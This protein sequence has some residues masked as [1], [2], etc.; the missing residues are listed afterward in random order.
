VVVT[1]DVDNAEDNGCCCRSP[2][3]RT[4]PLLF[5]I[6]SGEDLADP[7]HQRGS[8]GGSSTLL[9]EWRG[10]AGSRPLVTPLS[11]ASTTPNLRAPFLHVFAV[12]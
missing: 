2:A 7:R 11:N 9:S 8:R 4:L 12:L 3:G 10:G 1:I 6:V 5:L